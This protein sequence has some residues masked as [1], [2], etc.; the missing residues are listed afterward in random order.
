MTPSSAAADKQRDIVTESF[1]FPLPRGITPP[2]ATANTEVS[3]VWPAGARLG[4]SP[5]WDAEEGVLYW[6]DI[7]GR[8]IY[9]YG[10]DDDVREVFEVDRRV[11]AI[12]LRRRD[13]FVVAAERDVAFWRPGAGFDV[14]ATPEINPD[15]RLNDGKCDPHGR[16]WFGSMHEPQRDA[17]GSLYRLSPGGEVAV[18]DTQYCV[19]NGPAFSPDGST[20]YHTDSRRGVIYAFDCQLDGELCRRR[21]F[22]RIDP[23]QGVPDGMTVDAEGGLWVAHFGGA[24]VTR[25]TTDGRVDRIIAL[26]VSN[27]TSACFGGDDL[28]TLFITTASTGL[29][30]A[31]REQPPLAGGLFAVSLDIRGLP[32]PRYAG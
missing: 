26:P 13:G 1:A 25:F 20:A 8:R 5:T 11:G 6:V 32:S 7:D 21:T 17:V 19:A 30:A 15:T 24:R 18:A 2:V 14:I 31:Q 16:F 3:C 9:R 10:P 23:A 27:V 4:E 28:S 22:V 29:D 12:A